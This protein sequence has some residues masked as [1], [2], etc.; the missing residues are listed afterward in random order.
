MKAEKRVARVFEDV[1]GY[2]VCDD[3][4]DFLDMRGRAYD[5][6]AEAL[7]AAN[8]SGYTHATG[9]GTYWGNGVRAIARYA[10]Y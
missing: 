4:E 3:A 2:Y 8:R 1:G 9:S 10:E 7:R 5:T 6:K